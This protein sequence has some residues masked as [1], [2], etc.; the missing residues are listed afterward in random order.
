MKFLNLTIN[1]NN[2]TNGIPADLFILI[3]KLYTSKDEYQIFIETGNSKLNLVYYNCVKNFLSYYKIKNIFLSS[4]RLAFGTNTEVSS[5]LNLYFYS[6][7]NEKNIAETQVLKNFLNVY[8]NL[9][10]KLPF[11][12]ENKKYID[13]YIFINDVILPLSTDITL[14]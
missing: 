3:G 8:E 7:I 11:Y 10:G 6:K 5:K 13:K 14:H 12:I 9:F 2:L 4:K 1:K